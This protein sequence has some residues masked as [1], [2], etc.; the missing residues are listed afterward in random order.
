MRVAISGTIGVGK[1]TLCEN[2]LSKNPEYSSFEIFSEPVVMNPYFEDFYESPQRWAFTAQIYMI[3]HRFQRQ[4][5]AV[6]RSSG[7]QDFL[8]DRCF[9]EDRVF[10]E[11]NKEMGNI[12]DREFE[13]YINLFECF[14]RIVP[15][16]EKILY[17]RITPTQALERI[18]ARGRPQELRS[19]GLDYL[20][21]LHE[22]YEKWADY[23]SSRTQVKYLDW[24]RYGVDVL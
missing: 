23:M 21:R 1:T 7:A 22:A 13:T 17:L 12:S 11:V 19:I 15:P 4:M 16:P 8:L 24:S 6:H 2:L 10:A 18:K 9:H 5:D 14:E 3:S 20:S